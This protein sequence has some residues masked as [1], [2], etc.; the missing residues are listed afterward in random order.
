MDVGSLEHVVV[1]LVEIGNRT[2]N[3][4]TDMA[5]VGEGLETAPD[6]DIG[7]LLVPRVSIVRLVHVDP[8]LDLDLAGAVVDLECNVCRLR[9]HSSDLSDKCDLGDWGTV[10][11]EVGAGVCLF[12]VKNLLDGD[13]TEGFILVSLSRGRV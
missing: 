7:V 4:G 8:L 2:D 12:G 5:L 6:A 11:A 1:D 10:D 13:R 3:V 9:V